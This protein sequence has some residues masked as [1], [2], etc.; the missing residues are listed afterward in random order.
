[1]LDSFAEEIVSVFELTENIHVREGGDATLKCN[2]GKKIN[3]NMTMH[4]ERCII[5]N[6]YRLSLTRGIHMDDHI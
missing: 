5:F 2:F 3:E 6:K 1:M 4:K